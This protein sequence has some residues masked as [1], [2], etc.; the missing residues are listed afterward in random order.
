M[1][2]F[3]T[4]GLDHLT[5][6]QWLEAEQDGPWMAQFF[7]AMYLLPKKGGLADKALGAW[8]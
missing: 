3:F 7:L 1:H 6:Y 5:L 4:F 2:K 8:K